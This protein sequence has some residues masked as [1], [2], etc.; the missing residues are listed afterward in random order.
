MEDPNT[1]VGVDMQLDFKGHH[2]MLFRD[3]VSC[4]FKTKAIA[5]IHFSGILEAEDIV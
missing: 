2:T 3:Y 4:S 1:A 5:T